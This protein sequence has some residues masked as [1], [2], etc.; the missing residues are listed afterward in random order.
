MEKLRTIGSL[1]KF[2][3]SKKKYWLLPVVLVLIITAVLLFVF[4]GS[5]IT[6]FIYTIF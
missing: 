2:I 1:F 3:F 5:S 6:P 4:A